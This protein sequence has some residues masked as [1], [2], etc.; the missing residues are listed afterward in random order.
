ML[1][2]E[3]KFWQHY[4]LFSKIVKQS[5]M[6]S[7]VDGY[8]YYQ[9][10]KEFNF[11]NFLEIGFFEGQTCG[12]LAEISDPLAVIDA[13]DPSADLSIF[14]QIYS[15]QSN[16]INLWNCASQSFEFKKKYDCIIVD[17][18]KS[19]ESITIDIRNSLN[20]LAPHG[21]LLINEYQ[22]DSVQQAINEIV[23]KFGLIPFLKTDQTLF[24]H[25][26]EDLRCDFLDYKISHKVN[27]FINFYNE[28]INGHMVLM[29]K[30][31]PIFTDRLDF[32]D[33]ALKE[34]NI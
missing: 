24:F 7:T 22:L 14:K 32:F 3:T 19:Y 10:V 12:L 20:S 18:D 34:Y 17:G 15:E 31:L 5:S 28:E 13:V 16:K 9:L 8:V 23:V 11:I 4:G 25:R 2:Y 27:N 33:A 29:V 30:T 21:V 1:F 6:R 26:P